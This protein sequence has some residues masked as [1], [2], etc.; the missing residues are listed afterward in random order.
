MQA[1]PW[2]LPS[3]RRGVALLTTMLLVL[4]LLVAVTAAFTR[5]SSEFRTANDQTA[6]V[7]AFALAQSGL[8]S[9]VAAQ[10]TVPA[11]LPDSQVFSFA[12]GQAVVTLRA[13]RISG[14]D[15]VLV[16]VSRGENTTTN[17]YASDAAQATRTVAQLVRFSTGNFEAPSAL[18]VLGGFHQ[19]G[20]SATY[21]GVDACG[22]VPAIP[23]IALPTDS[24]SYTSGGGG[25]KGGGS[26]DTYSG[27][28][29]SPDDAPYEMGT[30]Q[31]AADAIDIDWAG[32]VAGTA[33]PASAHV[34]T[35][36]GNKTPTGWQSGWFP[37][38]PKA[39]PWPIVMVDGASQTLSNGMS[40]YGILI[41]TGDADING[42]WDWDGIVLIGGAITGNGNNNIR[43]ALLVGLNAK[44]G[45]IPN[46][47]DLS[48]GTKLVEYNSCN[49]GSA[50]GQFAGW[51]RLGNAWVDSWPS[52]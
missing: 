39:N 29:G 25:K 20:A 22:Q 48:N 32:I 27:I 38:S 42:N 35:A 49:I 24:F 33:L 21:S 37:A 4:L 52:Y 18:T 2:L 9:Y 44:L 36:A 41:V 3:D 15:T 6:V 12:G 17:R 40:G 28:D 11:S 7:D 30:V 34:V 8:D 16:L 19:N 43:G 5:S 10:A 23:G 50:M 31:E 14:A 1:T 47:S 45:L 13:A 51:S 26:S 46:Q